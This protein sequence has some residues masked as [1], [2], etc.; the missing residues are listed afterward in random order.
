MACWQLLMWFMWLMCKCE[1]NSEHI[2]PARA[3]VPRRSRA[4]IL[5]C[6]HAHTF[7]GIKT[8]A[9]DASHFMSDACPRD[10]LEIL[11]PV[12]L[13]NMMLSS[14]IIVALA[15]LA[16]GESNDCSDCGCVSCSSLSA[17][18]HHHQSVASWSL[19]ENDASGSLFY[20]QQT[21][22]ER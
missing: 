8:H 10:L 19:R 6:T 3:P 5:Y 11:T 2:P 12:F 17:A 22:N 21:W 18:Q 13:T 14:A 20:F 7:G 15:F 9:Q 4:Y 1:Q 16:V